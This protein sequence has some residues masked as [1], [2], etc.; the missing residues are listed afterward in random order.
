MQKLDKDEILSGI[1]DLQKKK[2]WYVSIIWRPNAGKSTFLNAL[3]WEKVSIVSNVPQT[4]RKKVL[5]IYNDESSQ[6]VFIDTPWIHKSVKS[7]NEAINSEAIK[8]LNSADAVLYFIDSTREGWE[9]E[10]FI[11]ENL[12]KV[13]VPVIKVYTKVDLRPVITLPEDG[14]KISSYEWAWFEDVLGELKKYLKEDFALYPEEYYTTS[15]VHFRISEIIREKVFLN[16]KEEIPH[17]SFVEVEEYEDKWHL[18]RM[19]AYIYVETDSQKYIV[20]WKWGGLI[21]KIW[22]EAREEL[23]KLYDKKVFLALKV[24][25]LDKWR[26][27]ENVVKKIFR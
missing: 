26:K 21:T 13:K 20:V 3:I 2:V 24:K 16:T 23:E 6:I 1:K 12:S 4:T 9:E 19:V 5:W 7:F 18:L 17:S 27:K 15:D 8:T 22:K 10:A 25:K 11:K 14:L